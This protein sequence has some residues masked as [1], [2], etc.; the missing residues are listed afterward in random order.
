MKLFKIILLFCL[1]N[2]S[3]IF[4]KT[5]TIGATPNPFASLLEKVKDDFK[6]KG[7]ELKIIEFSDYILPNRALEE[8]ELDANLYQHKPFL[9]EY[10]AQKGTNLTPTTPVVI[11]PVGIYS[12]TIKDLKNLKKGARVAIPNDATNE[13]RALELLEKAGLIELNQNT[14]KTP[15]DI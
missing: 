5:I 8:K 2:L 1:L 12:K 14:L 11:A 13:S 3:P 10:N 4:A 15:L 7:Y 9:E 6:D